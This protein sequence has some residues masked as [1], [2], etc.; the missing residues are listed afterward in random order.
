MKK[1]A[2]TNRMIKNN[3][4][5]NLSLSSKPTCEIYSFVD[6]VKVLSLFNIS[7]I[8]VMKKN[9]QYIVMIYVIKESVSKSFSVLIVNGLN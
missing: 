9:P 1:M 2:F 6:Y 3:A 8:F 7:D 5:E 4:S